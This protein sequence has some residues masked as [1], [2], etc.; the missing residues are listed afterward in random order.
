ML[1]LRS[2]TRR[3]R[4]A[5]PRRTPRRSARCSKRWRV[6]GARAVQRCPCALRV[7]LDAQADRLDVGEERVEERGLPAKLRLLAR[8]LMGRLHALDGAVLLL[9]ELC[10]AIEGD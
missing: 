2:T 4:R 8:E 6:S 5:T 3:W 1:R 10:D 9:G 7:A